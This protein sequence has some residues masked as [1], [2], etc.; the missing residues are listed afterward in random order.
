MELPLVATRIPG[1]IEATRDGETGFLVPMK[2]AD[3]LVSATRTYVRDAELRRRH[4][5]NGRRFMESDFAPEFL[6]DLLQK[7]KL[8]EA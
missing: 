2:D 3:A 1:C 4:G 5:A 8:Q 7:A 6:Q